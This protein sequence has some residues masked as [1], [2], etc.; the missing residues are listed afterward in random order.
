MRAIVYSETGTPDVLR[1]V[2]RD[3]PQPG[4]GEVRV[5]ILV[6]GVNPTDWK[7]RAGSRP[8]EALSFPEVVP[9]QDGAGIVDAVGTGVERLDV[10]DRVWTAI[11]AY[12]LASGGTAQDFTVLPAERVYPLPNSASF[13]L[14]ATLGVPAMT[15]HRALTVAEN[16]PRR[17]APGALTGRTVLVAGGAGAV[18][19]AAIELARWAG[20]TVITTV[21]SAEKGA[22]ASAAGAHHVVNYR[23]TDA[24]RAIRALAPEGVDLVVEVAPAQNAALNT[25]VIRTRGSIAVYATTGGPLALDIRSQMTLNVRYQFQL[26]YTLGQDLL[27]AAAADIVSAIRDD[28][29]HVGAEAG[30]PL[31]HFPL[32][33]TAEA[34]AAVEAGVVGKVLIDLAP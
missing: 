17:L 27:D 23:E 13:D 10:G 28:A 21:S 3:L 9:N 32:E 30:L 16:G 20:A 24:A 7:S 29:L 14:G 1:L 34:H 25:A 19:H 15:A 2:E 6:S 18:G 11:A 4:P 33:S 8:G 12:G 31:H 5:R 22:L 26:L